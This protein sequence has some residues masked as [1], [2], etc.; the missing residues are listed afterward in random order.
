[1][2]DA[3]PH[4]AKSIFQRSNSNYFAPV[5]ILLSG[6]AQFETKSPILGIEENIY[7]ECIEAWTDRE[8]DA[9]KCETCGSPTGDNCR[10]EEDE[11][12]EF[13][14]EQLQQSLDQQIEDEKYFRELQEDMDAE[15]SMRITP[16]TLN[17]RK[18]KIIAILN[19]LIIYILFF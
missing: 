8:S 4:S 1:M 2:D 6:M 10:S 18:G 19:T 3:N 16:V 5:A 7:N 15:E 11:T 17:M 9:E 12:N 13:E 14:E